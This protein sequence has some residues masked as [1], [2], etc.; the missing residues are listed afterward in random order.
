MLAR[1]WDFAGAPGNEEIEIAAFV[2]LQ[3]RA[4]EQRRVAA[5]GHRRGAGRAARRECGSAP[6]SSASSTSSSM[7]RPA[8]SSRIASP[9]RTSASG[10]P[11][12]DSGVMCSTIVPN[13]VPL[14]RASEIRTMSLTPCGA[15]FF[16]IGR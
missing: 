10:P 4:M 16:G 11:I 5:L 14:M 1:R 9:S 13:A 3:H 6:A 8:T 12:A 7:R 15:S 2:G